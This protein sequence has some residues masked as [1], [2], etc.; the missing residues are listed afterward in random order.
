MPLARTMFL[1]DYELLH[2]VQALDRKD[3]KSADEVRKA[4]A[5]SRLS[6]FKE[7]KR[8]WKDIGECKCRFNQLYLKD[9]RFVSFWEEGLRH[10]RMVLKN[11]E[12][13]ANQ[14]GT[15][16]TFQGILLGYDR[17]AYSVSEELDHVAGEGVLDQ[18]ILD[19]IQ[20]RWMRLDDL[21]DWY[22]DAYMK[23]KKDEPDSFRH[24][25]KWSVPIF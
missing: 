16:R 12:T 24:A 8:Q 5:S 25:P 17:M 4:K 1:F 15:R 6:E 11:Q 7:I 21:L 19:S 20:E 13:S 9:K 3:I 18:E 10:V 2:R 22:F 14:I 23:C